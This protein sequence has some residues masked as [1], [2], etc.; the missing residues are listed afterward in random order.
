MTFC[1]GW[2]DRGEVFIVADTALSSFD[3]TEKIEGVSSFGENYGNYANSV[4]EEKAL[5]LIRLNEYSLVTFSGDVKAAFDAIE[6]LKVL[7]D[8]NIIHALEILKNNFQGHQNFELLIAT[9]QDGNRLYHFDNKNGYAE[10]H[11]IKGIG[12]GTKDSDIFNPIIEFLEEHK[13]HTGD[14][15]LLL[16][17]MVSFLQCFSLK[18]HL[19]RMGVGGAFFGARLED[20]IVWCSDLLYI[21][22]SN[23]L[24]A[25]DKNMVSVISRYNSVFSASGFDGLNKYFLNL[26]TDKVFLQNEY[27]HNSVGKVLKTGYPDYLIVYSPF[28]NNMFIIETKKRVYNSVV[29][30][31]VKQYHD[32]TDY[33]FTFNSHFVIMANSNNNNN[34]SYIPSY[35]QVI[36]VPMNYTPREKLIIE[37]NLTS[38]VKDNQ[39]IY[40]IDLREIDNSLG[41]RLDKSI[42]EFIGKYNFI[43]IIDLNYFYNKLIDTYEY[44]KGLDI[45]FETMKIET[46]VK[47]FVYNIDSENFDKYGIILITQEK[48]SY[49]H[50]GFDFIDWLTSYENSYVVS[51][52]KDFLMYFKCFLF[53]YFKNYYHNE[54]YF[55]LMRSY[56]MQDSE[57]IN[58]VLELTPRY[59]IDPSEVPDFI[60]IRNNNKETSVNGEYKYIIMENF[61]EKMFKLVPSQLALWDPIKQ[62][63]SF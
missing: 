55:H 32:R 40:D 36:A 20:E 52:N 37:A 49:I 29:N 15:N 16:T 9:K 3:L 46:L 31:Y 48:Q 24:L 56:I 26:G 60:V 6:A 30:M 63:I 62:E 2:K 47:D 61:I 1:L 38:Q 8:D 5:K 59:N 50:N 19:F 21:I 43:I 57:A 42:S 34:N 17:K 54:K 27:L 10:V 7:I 22:Y 41:Y 33:A 35:T 58:E 28:I 51:F 4:V 23:D 53:E 13:N 39:E 25:E 11:N 45:D 12:G 14:S 18:N 44:Y